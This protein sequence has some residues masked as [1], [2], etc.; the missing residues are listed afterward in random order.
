MATKKNIAA[1]R[2][3][4]E[5][6]TGPKSAEGKSK[7]SMNALRHGLYAGTVILPEENR[8]DYDRLYG[9][10]QEKLE[11]QTTYEQDLVSQFVLI[12]W[13]R[14]RAELIEASLL[15]EYGDES[16]T[17]Y[18]ATYAR[19]MRV[20][21]VLRRD[22]NK[23]REQLEKVQSA[24]R[25]EEAAKEQPA[26]E[27]PKQPESEHPITHNPSPG[28]PSG[29]GERSEPEPDDEQWAT[30]EE[31]LT[32]TGSE[33]NYKRPKFLEMWWTPIKGEPPKLIARIYKGK[34][35]DEW[36][37]DDQP[38]PGEVWSRQGKR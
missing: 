2:A 31:F 37:A 17:V 3:N 29:P 14:L 11:P 25:R 32:Q 23:L 24:R 21:A 36:P 27:A 18:S 22:R 7:S 10:Y 6:S 28:V 8:E 33:K 15:A 5:K 9:Y 4:A 19:I 35:V 16:A 13:K 1:N 12:E 20:E 34:N 38:D 30:K 26:K